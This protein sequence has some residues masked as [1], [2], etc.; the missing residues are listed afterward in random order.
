MTNGRTTT[1]LYDPS[2]E[3][4][5]CGVG[6]VCQVD[7]AASHGLGD[8]ALTMLEDRPCCQEQNPP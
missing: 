6:F 2:F 7:G 8:D 1:G 4:D 3:H 5:A